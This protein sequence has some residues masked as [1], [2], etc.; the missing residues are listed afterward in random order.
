MYVCMY[1]KGLRS[2]LC[3]VGIHGVYVNL[4]IAKVKTRDGRDLILLLA[5]GSTFEDKLEAK[6]LQFLRF[7]SFIVKERLVPIILKF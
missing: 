4:P 7:E 2:G 1:P 6:N 5:T 3:Q